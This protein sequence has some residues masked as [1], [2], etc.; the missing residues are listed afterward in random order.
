ADVRHVRAGV[1]PAGLADE[2]RLA[3]LDQVRSAMTR[4]YN[5]VARE[6]TTEY[7]WVVEDDV[8]PPVDACERLLR[9]FDADTS[10]VTGVYPS[11]WRDGFVV[12]EANQQKYTVRGQGVQR[13]GGNGFGCVVLRGGVLRGTVFSTTIDHPAYDNAFYHR[14]A[15][16]GLAAKFDW[17]VECEHRTEE[18]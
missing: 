4:I 13:V 3:A 14:L 5:W 10:S 8:L 18:R 11:R 16:T 1:G 17:S 2:P 12:W 6:A 15:A 9:A 7:V